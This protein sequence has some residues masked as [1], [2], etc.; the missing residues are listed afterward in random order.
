VKISVKDG[1]LVGLF[2]LERQE[3]LLRFPT[4]KELQ[5]DLVEIFLGQSRRLLVA[6]GE[7]KNRVDFVPTYHL[8]DDEIFEIPLDRELDR[9]IEGVQSPLTLNT[10]DASIHSLSGLKSLLVSAT[11]D[12]TPALIIQ[13]FKQ[14]R[15]LQKGPISIVF[16]N[17]TFKRLK[18]DGLALDSRITG[19]ATKDALLF[20]SYAGMRGV[21]D[22][23]PHYREATNEQV[24]DFALSKSV[25]VEDPQALLEAADPFIRKR[26]F[27]V[28]ESKVLEVFPPKALRSAAIRF[29]VDLQIVK[30]KGK[31]RVV[32]PVTRRELKKVI[33]F[34]ADDYLESSFSRLLYLSNSKLRV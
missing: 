21:F 1:V 9:F 33:R 2:A 12:G 14:T 8:E 3:M 15:I 7:P 10:Y 32:L 6:E 20:E 30:H 13:A 22:M 25:Y 24:S 16:S 18:E 34:L 23:K 26:M 28:F 11:L 29:G 31:E 27:A 4:S 19:I 17:D 5:D